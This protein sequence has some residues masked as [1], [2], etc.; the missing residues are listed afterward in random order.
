MTGAGAGAGVVAVSSPQVVALQPERR[1]LRSRPRRNRTAVPRKGRRATRCAS[2]FP[3]PPRKGAANRPSPCRLLLA[4][5]D[6]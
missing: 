5:M 6:L 1:L 4:H 2:G 3:S